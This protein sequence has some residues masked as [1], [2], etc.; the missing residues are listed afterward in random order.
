MA[1]QLR[2]GAVRLSGLRSIASPMRSCAA[3]FWGFCVNLGH[4]ELPD[5][6]RRVLGEVKDEPRHRAALTYDICKAR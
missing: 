4:A 1:A 5:L 6:R 3:C 2:A